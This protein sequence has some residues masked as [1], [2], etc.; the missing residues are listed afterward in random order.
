[1]QSDE[2]LLVDA[3]KA[4]AAFQETLVSGRAPFDEFRDALEGSD[5]TQLEKYPLAAQRGLRIFVGK[6]TAE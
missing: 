4:L 5:L 6:G 1:V 2:E 3:G